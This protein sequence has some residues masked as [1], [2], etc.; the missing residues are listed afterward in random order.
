MRLREEFGEGAGRAEGG[1]AVG[2][3]GSPRRVQRRR[4][5]LARLANPI[6]TFAARKFIEAGAHALDTY[7]LLTFQMAG[8]WLEVDGT[9]RELV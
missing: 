5:P 6:E 4:S 8:A 2:I 9:P 1:G 3:P 7:W